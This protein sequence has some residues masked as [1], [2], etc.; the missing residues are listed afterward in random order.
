MIDIDWGG[1][2]LTILADRALYWPRRKTLLI[3]DPHFGK[4]ATFRQAGIPIPHGTTATDLDRLRALVAGT[5]A[6][7][8]VVLGDFFHARSGRQPG[9]LDAIAPVREEHGQL[10]IVLVRGNHDDHAGDPP[11]EWRFNCA[12]EPIREEPFWLAPSSAAAAERFRTGRPFAS[13]P[14]ARRWWWLAA[15]CVFL[16]SDAG[17]GVAGFWAFYRRP[18]RAAQ[19]RRPGVCRRSGRSRGDSAA[20]FRPGRLPIATGAL[21]ARFVIIGQH[22][23]RSVFLSGVRRWEIRKIWCRFIRRPT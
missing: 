22:Y 14:V 12:A 16:V 10:E 6:E 20:D 15:Q 21:A 8:L 19:C 11:V 7:R 17:G 3:A 18:R 9:T 13:G 1:E 2:R 5:A 23:R 4:A